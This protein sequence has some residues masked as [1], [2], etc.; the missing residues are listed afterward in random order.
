MNVNYY[1]TVPN[2]H[3]WTSLSGVLWSLKDK[4][5]RDSSGIL[6]S[7]GEH[8]LIGIKNIIKKGYKL[9]KINDNKIISLEYFTYVSE[10]VEY[11]ESN[12]YN[13]EKFIQLL[14]NTLNNG[15]DISYELKME[16]HDVYKCIDGERKYQDMHWNTNLRENQVPDEDKPVAEWLNYIEYNLSKAKY[17]NYHLNKEGALDELRK[18]AALAVRAMEIHG[19]PERQINPEIQ[20]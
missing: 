11:M 14:E 7:S 16:R 5:C 12:E 20:L 10:I 15:F 2:S 9:K 8:I 18:V 19:C 6:T 13:S 3:Y 4:K 1:Q 17:E